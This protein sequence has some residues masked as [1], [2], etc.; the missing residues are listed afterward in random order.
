MKAAIL[1]NKN[2]LARHSDTP[3]LPKSCLNKL[4]LHMLTSATT[5]AGDS[6]TL[7]TLAVSSSLCCHSVVCSGESHVLSGP[8]LEAVNSTSLPDVGWHSHRDQ[9]YIRFPSQRH[10]G[11]VVALCIAS[12]FMEMSFVTCWLTANPLNCATADP[13]FTEEYDKIPVWNIS[14]SPSSLQSSSFHVVTS[15]RSA[16]VLMLLGDVGPLWPV[17]H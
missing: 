11:G 10:P 2:A 15:L 3:F 8:L 7:F 14:Q 5:S 1:Q 9:F 4:V 12:L 17:T 16:P 6:T 13:A